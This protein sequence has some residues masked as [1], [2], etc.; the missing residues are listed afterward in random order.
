MQAVAGTGHGSDYGWRSIV[1]VQPQEQHQPVVY[2]RGLTADGADYT[3]RISA[4]VTNQPPPQRLPA[5]QHIPDTLTQQKQESPGHQSQRCA[6]HVQANLGAADG[7]HA[8]THAPSHHMPGLNLCDAGEYFSRVGRPALYALFRAM[9]QAQHHARST[10]CIV[11]II[12]KQR[13]L[14]QQS[15]NLSS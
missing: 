1:P 3:C 13:S 8:V 9:P 10:A 15:V 4:A 12:I 7:H 6:S 5:S 11:K 14:C 2:P